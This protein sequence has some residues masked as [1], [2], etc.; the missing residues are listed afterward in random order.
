MADTAVVEI[1]QV[2]DIKRSEEIMDY[3]CLDTLYDA[4]AP[5]L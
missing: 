2:P 4:C 5:T 1:N 3:F